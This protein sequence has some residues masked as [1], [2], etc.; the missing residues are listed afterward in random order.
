VIEFLVAYSF[1]GTS[2][3]TPDLRGGDTVAWLYNPAGDLRG[4]QQYDA[5]AFADASTPAA[6]ADAGA[7]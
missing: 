4:C 5:G 1:A 2:S 6:D 3:H 7:E